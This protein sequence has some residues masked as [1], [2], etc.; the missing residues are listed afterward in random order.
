MDP[1]RAYNSFR[2]L[3][4]KLNLFLLLLLLFQVVFIINS[5]VAVKVPNFLINYLVP[6]LFQSN[7][8]KIG[9]TY[10]TA[11]NLINFQ[12]LEFY[13][14]TNKSKI[15]IDN[16]SIKLNSY[17][18]YSM[19]AIDEIIINEIKIIHNNKFL[20]SEIDNFILLRK[21]NK[22]NVIFNY[23]NRKLSSSVK[24]V[25][26]NKYAAKNFTKF[27]NNKQFKN[28]YSNKIFQF[29]DDHFIS[30]KNTD[31]KIQLSCVFFIDNLSSFKIIQ[32]S[33]H[34]KSSNLEG[35]N[36][37]WNF[38]LKQNSSYPVLLN[39]K[40]VTLPI[41]ESEF[42]FK[43][44]S[45]SLLKVVSNSKNDNSN[46]FAEFQF[47]SI[48]SIGKFIGKIPNAYLNLSKK[49]ELIDMTIISDSNATTCSNILK[50]GLENDLFSINGQNTIIPDLINV[51]VKSEDSYSRIIKGDLLNLNFSN[52]F[53]L[54]LND[55]RNN[56]WITAKAFSVLNSAFGDYNA[57]GIIK[58][59]ISLFLTKV[60][61]KLGHS[62]LNGSFSQEWRPMIFN[63]ILEGNCLPTDINNWLGQ[64]WD[65]LW[66]DFKFN[67]HDVPYGKFQITGN[68]MES[69][70]S[71]TNGVIKSQNFSYKGTP[72]ENSTI[73]LIVDNNKTYIASKNIEHS[74]G[75][76]DGEISIPHKKNKSLLPIK[77]SL[78]GIYPINSGKK[79]FG[80][81]IEDYLNDFNLSFLTINSTGLLH[82][83]HNKKHSSVDLQDNYIIQV[84][85]DQNGTWNGINFS[86]INGTIKSDSNR[87][88]LNFPTIKLADGLL[89]LTLDSNLTSKE[90]YLK[91]SLKNTEILK[92]YKSIVSFQNLTGNVLFSE[93]NA[94]SFTKNGIIELSLNAHGVSNNLM[95]F[96]GSGLIR[97]KDKKL[98]QI[99]LLGFISDGLSKLP[100]P[101]PSGTLKFNTLEGLFELNNGK[102]TF[103]NL[104]LKGHLS[105]V[106]S[107]GSLDLQS[108]NLDI[109]T[110]IHLIGNFPIPILSQITKLADPISI[111][112]ELKITGH[113]TNPNW[114]ISLN[115][116]K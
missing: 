20:N 67:N 46:Y 48:N 65:N 45:S 77:Y 73:N 99:N 35:F 18:T 108:G 103:D 57:S 34:R 70:N 59:D 28:E 115:P 49:D 64:W 113:W 51:R 102:I 54:S 104:V 68:W 76:I 26:N 101:F 8:V 13:E 22:F 17:F 32:D 66:L 84:S 71:Y 29:I 53:P 58:D 88:I 43:K 21:N 90:N 86:S 83:V 52:P 114:E 60:S 96:K 97:I 27:K 1:R 14:K 62:V 6:Q 74:F 69:S 94:T 24:G 19:E 105:K 30:F 10:F 50:F 72:I 56:I 93:D 12:K 16:L 95:S 55:S 42:E 7:N 63:F 109:L 15:S 2:T 39:I 107:K 106:A 91:L 80:P 79:T 82:E 41:F 5:F 47:E 38:D 75:S 110:K 92:L 85:T 98:N 4:Q 111:I 36:F 61:G 3:K 81:I 78:S 11:P 112:P 33:S 37:L 44:I 40:K 89:S 87:L 25:I 31:N 9:S 100:L 23:N 116:L